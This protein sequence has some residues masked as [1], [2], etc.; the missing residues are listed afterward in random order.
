MELTHRETEVLR[1][2]KDGKSSWD[3]SIIL[4]CSK[5]VVDFHVGNIKKK[6]NAASRAQAVAIGLHHGII[7][8]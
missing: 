2:I 8:F 1:W 4:K 3:I 6:L 5:R 7:T